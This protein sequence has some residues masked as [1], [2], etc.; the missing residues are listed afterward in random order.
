MFSF[1]KDWI[2]AMFGEAHSILKRLSD[3]DELRPLISKME[4]Y[5]SLE[6][7]SN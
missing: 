1:Q 2:P 5:L 7:D 4:A 3:T 6:D